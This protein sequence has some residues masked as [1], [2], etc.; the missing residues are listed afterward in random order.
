M[1]EMNGED[2]A[3]G[4]LWGQEQCAGQCLPTGSPEE[5]EP[6]LPAPLCS[7]CMV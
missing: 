3:G 5:E 7:I 4:G 1:G 2:I 6:P